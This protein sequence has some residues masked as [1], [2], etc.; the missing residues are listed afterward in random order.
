MRCVMV[1]Y[2]VAVEIC[3]GADGHGKERSVKADEVRHGA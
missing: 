1:G 3:Y 2:G